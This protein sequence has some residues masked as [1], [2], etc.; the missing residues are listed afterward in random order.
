MNCPEYQLTI[1]RKVHLWI[2]SSISW[3]IYLYLC[4]DDNVLTLQLWDMWVLQFC[5]F[6]ETVWLFWVS[7]F[8]IWFLGLACLFLKTGSWD[9]DRYVVESTYLSITTL[10]I[11]SLPT[12]EHRYPAIYLGL[13]PVHFC[14]FFSLG[15]IT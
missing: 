12:H 5:F 3:F 4:Q 8:S 7:C 1:S 9:F 13:R 6:S 11:V 14:I 2:L 10:T 15:G